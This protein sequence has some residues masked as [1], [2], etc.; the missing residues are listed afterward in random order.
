VI[1]AIRSAL[2]TTAFFLNTTLMLL[3]GMPV[4]LL[5]SERQ[6]T[7]YA[8]AWGRVTLFLLRVLA[9]IRVEV[10]GREH[11]PTGAA[12]IAAKHQSA[13]ETFALLP[14]LADPTM[15]MKAELRRVPLFGTYSVAAGM[16]L[17][18]RS[19]GGAALRDM[20]QRGREEAAKGRQ[21]VI[22]PEGTRRPP[23]APPAY[24]PGVA[25]LY[26]GLNL[27]TVPVALNSGLY[28]PRRSFFKYPGTI[29]VEFLPPIE[30]GLDSKAF[31]AR[32]EAA[33]EGGSDRL[34]AEAASLPHPPPL[35]ETAR[36]RLAEMSKVQ[37][38]S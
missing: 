15:V 7:R 14:I 11:I 5:G 31:L 32:L 30:A 4:F 24:Q 23:G 21:I 1:T 13:F 3:V 20:V 34:L 33:I 17:V 38:L 18:D 37:A 29:V 36:E 9:G 2:F 19:K 35:P 28:W 8:Q 27:P 16:I 26:R 25:L 22:F 12:L 6:S 10:R